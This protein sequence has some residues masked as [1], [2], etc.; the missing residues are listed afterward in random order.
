MEI[1]RQASALGVLLLEIQS[2]LSLVILFPKNK[3]LQKQYHTEDMYQSRYLSP[4]MRAIDSP[5][6]ETNSFVR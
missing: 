6:C 1:M 5:L 2:L 4:F 3:L